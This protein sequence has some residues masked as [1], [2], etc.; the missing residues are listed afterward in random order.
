MRINQLN[1]LKRENFAKIVLKVESIAMIGIHKFVGFSGG[2]GTSPAPAC[3]KLVISYN[4]YRIV[5]F[6][7]SAQL[8][9]GD[10]SMGNQ[11]PQARDAA[12][13]TAGV[14]PSRAEEYTAAEANLLSAAPTTFG[15][16]VAQHG[17]RSGGADRSSPSSQRRS[18]HSSPSAP[19]VAALAADA[20]RRAAPS[21]P[22]AVG[23]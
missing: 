15:A 16:P 6:I 8:Q 7:Q 3:R 18:M 2:R 17:D 11:C 23:R 10:P 4:R 9:R 5:E 12:Q 22:H 13:T 21:A 1:V 20:N 14:G 19:P